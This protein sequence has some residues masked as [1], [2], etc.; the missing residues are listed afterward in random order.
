MKHNLDYMKELM[1]IPSPTLD[2]LRHRLRTCEGMLE[3]HPEHKDLLNRK[4]EETKQY[5]R[6]AGGVA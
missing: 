4:I 3:R 1:R 6:E 2:Q 5:I